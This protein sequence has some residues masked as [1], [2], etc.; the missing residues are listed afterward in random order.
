[1]NFLKK[2][3]FIIL[4]F[5]IGIVFFFPWNQV[6]D[7]ITTTVSKSSGITLDMQNLE[8]T[9]GLRI[10]LSKGSVLGFSAS[11][12]HIRS[13]MGQS[14]SCEELI[15]A[16]RI[17]P[18]LMGQLQVGIG[19]IEKESGSFAALLKGSPFWAPT[20]LSAS[21]ELKKFSLENVDLQNEL[22]GIF[23]GSLEV[24]DISLNG[25]SLPSLIWDLSAN[26]V[27]SPSL[28]TP[29]L[30]LPSLDLD[31][32]KTVGS[33]SRNTLKIPTLN[34]GSA[35]STIQG[36]LS[37]ESDLPM[38]SMAPENGQLSGSLRV[39]PS[40][41]TS[42]FKDISLKIPFGPADTS[43]NRQIKKKFSGGIIN[44]FTSAYKSGE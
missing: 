25:K 33:L 22:H 39:S 24:N 15:I 16:P 13:P 27:R 17:W 42:T 23:S 4:G 7:F 35:Q 21:L 31:E 40:A 44:L 37:F 36:K 43:G 14:I 12:A 20:S 10:G 19:C 32:V 9:L 28:S 18:L 5:F 11:A 3:F 38:P 6:K 29:F 8:P 41:E 2:Y 30:T 34:F 26:E 1:M